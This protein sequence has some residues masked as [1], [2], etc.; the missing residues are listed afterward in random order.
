MMRG[1]PSKIGPAGWEVV[2]DPPVRFRRPP[3]MLSQAVPVAGGSITEDLLPLLNL[4]R[5][6]HRVLVTAA[7]R[8][9]ATPS[10]H[11][12]DWRA[13]SGPRAGPKEIALG[14]S[15]IG[16]ARVLAARGCGRS[17]GEALVPGLERFARGEAAWS[18]GRGSVPGTVPWSGHQ[19][20]CNRLQKTEGGP[21]SPR[22]TRSSTMVY[23][24]HPSTSAFSSPRKDSH[25]R[26]VCGNRSEYLPC[27]ETKPRTSRKCRMAGVG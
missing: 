18:P 2:K 5:Q 21:V 6:S 15:P 17:D 26:R 7:S 25:R 23:P 9:G 13:R 10:M 27:P 24:V 20:Y 4:T 14:R 8:F 12:G 11:A 22:S 3:G 16:R 1:K 19:G